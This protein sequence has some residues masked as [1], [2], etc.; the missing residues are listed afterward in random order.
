MS[1][2]ERCGAPGC[3]ARAAEGGPFCSTCWNRLPQTIRDEL[4]Q[5]VT[6]DPNPHYRD[7]YREAVRHLAAGQPA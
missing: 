5:T 6:R 3:E 1:P 4:C 2:F 7:A